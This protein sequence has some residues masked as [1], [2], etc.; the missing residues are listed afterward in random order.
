MSGPTTSAPTMS[1]GTAARLAAEALL[2]ALVGAGVRDA[3]ISPGSRNAPLVLALDRLHREGEPIRLHTILDERAAA[4]FALG[5]A[6]VSG[7]PTLFCC[8][9]GSAGA[10]ALP[11]VI[12]ADRAGLP[13]LALTA[14]RP[15]EL[16]GVGAPQTIAQ[17]GMLAPYVRLT[18]DPGAP[19]PAVS[20]DYISTIAARAVFAAL[21]PDPGPV[22]LNLPYREPLELADPPAPT[23]GFRPAPRV[24]RGPTRL[25]Q[26][27]IHALAERLIARPRGVLVSGPG[28]SGVA[29][30]GLSQ[31]AA[32]LGRALSSLAQ[33]LS[34]PILADGASPLRGHRSAD[35]GVVVSGD[36]LAR[37]R[38][39]AAVTP[40]IVVRFGQ[41]PTSRALTEWLASPHLAETWLVDPHGRFSDPDHAATMLLVADPVQLAS[42]L[43]DAIR[44]I[45]PR[46][47]P[48]WL[49]RWQQ[50]DAKAQR[51]LAACIEPCVE[52]WSGAIARTVAQALPAGALLH[53]ASSLPIRAYDAFA[54]APRAGV[55]VAANRGAN[56][57]D[58]TLA[59]A[60][61][62]AHRWAS[63][64][65]AAVVGDLA[66]LHDVGALLSCPPPEIPLVI[67]VVD[68]AGGGIFDHLPIARH[69]TAF[70][71]HFITRPRVDAESVARG[72]PV[73]FE[74]AA[75][76]AALAETLGRGLRTPGISI[77]HVPID[78]A[79][80][81]ACHKQA[82]AAVESA[83]T[84]SQPHKEVSP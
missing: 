33:T 11:A 27:E 3:V 25:P 19:D 12:E 59:T 66:F 45:G 80:D 52:P 50:S 23:G 48:R 69:P 55:T 54:P 83:L 16:H 34:W 74:S 40:D 44:G 8:T 71:P 42:D 30:P 67:V 39:G 60:L 20:L 72:L 63:G 64:P 56:G 84:D 41:V 10:H 7:Q 78:R 13:L 76:I 79:F 65:V 49:A 5:L 35:A 6:R 17:V 31:A 14:D 82:R 57:I 24:V 26:P 15:P 29:G 81:L 75:T 38:S 61:G 77:V 36:A 62:E 73:A 21:G 47:E 32:D 4:F 68:N 37:T 18:V 28:D 9:S 22:H 70:E 46:P 58:G 53:L 51:A 1:A 43:A 2:R